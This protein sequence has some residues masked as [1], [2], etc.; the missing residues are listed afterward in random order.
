MSSK[1]KFTFLMFLLGMLSAFGPFVT[2]LYLPAL[3]NLADYF[4]ATPSASQLSLT[5]SML[6]L[7]IGQLFIGPLSDKYGRKRLLVICLI[8]FVAGTCAC[9]YAPDIALFNAFRLVQG[10]AASGGIV[11]ARSVSADSYRGPVLTK[12]LA[13]VS[14]VNGVAPIVAPVLGGFLLNFMS[15]KGTFAVLLLYGFVL[16]FMAGKFQESLPVHRRSQK[17]ILANFSLY[18]KVFRNGEFVRFFAVCT[19]SMIVLFGYIAASPFIF[20]ALY[21]L[22]PIGF[23]LCFAMIAFCTAVGCATSGKIGNDRKAIKIAGFGIFVASLAVAAC[24]LTHAPLPLLQVSFMATT[25]M[26][27]LMQPPASALALNA[28]RK[29]AGTA[30]AAMGAAG[31][32][33]GGVASPIV[34]MGDIA[35]SASIML[36][37]GGFL[38][39]LFMIIAKSKMPKKG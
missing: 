16:L 21:G 18:V 19:A 10:L 20:Q 33:M 3:P 37:T 26:F 29:N 17:S 28:E 23:S 8:L 4:K 36:V 24:L 2:D 25:F 31:F 38:T 30:S 35:V 7:S 12:F 1:A 6:G 34:G 13:M 22:S 39:M 5:M 14:A 11:I 15:W 32:L 9:I 27:G